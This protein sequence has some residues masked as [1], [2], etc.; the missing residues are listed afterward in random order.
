M[1]NCEKPVIFEIWGRNC[2]KFIG[3]IGDE[4]KIEDANDLSGYNWKIKGTRL[5]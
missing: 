5:Q 2:K 1:Q 3:E 4:I